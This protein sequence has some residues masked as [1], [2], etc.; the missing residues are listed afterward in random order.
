MVE[1]KN[2]EM[3]KAY[4]VKVNGKE[5]FS[6]DKEDYKT[7][8][9]KQTP[10]R[11]EE[12]KVAEIEHNEFEEDRDAYI[13]L[14]QKDNEQEHYMGTIGNSTVLTNLDVRFESI[15]DTFMDKEK[16][17]AWIENPTFAEERQ[18]KEREESYK[19]QVIRRQQGMER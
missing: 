15:E 13:Y 4:I 18:A 3:D 12:V 17:K 10:E 16:A 5:Y 7:F 11:I 8:Y 2:S 6:F 1:E 14:V 9:S 19:R